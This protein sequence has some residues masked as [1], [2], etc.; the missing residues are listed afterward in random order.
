MGCLFFSLRTFQNAMSLIRTAISNSLIVTKNQGLQFSFGII[1]YYFSL[2]AFDLDF[3]K[4]GVNVQPYSYTSANFVVY[5]GLLLVGNL[6]GLD[7]PSGGNLSHG[8]Y[9]PSGK[10]V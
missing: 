2:A 5:T 4:W 3:E 1:N 8:Y 6:M 9:T 10:K 7:S